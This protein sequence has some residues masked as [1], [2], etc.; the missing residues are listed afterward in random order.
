MSVILEMFFKRMFDIVW[1]VAA[2]II[3]SSLSLWQ[4]CNKVAIKVKRSSAESD[5]FGG[6]KEL[7]R[8]QSQMNWKM[9]KK[10]GT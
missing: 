7:K 4:R 9:Q 2:F 8:P 5:C 1:L 10:D 3:N 6:K